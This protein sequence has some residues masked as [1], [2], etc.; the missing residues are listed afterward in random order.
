MEQNFKIG[1]IVKYTYIKYTYDYG[2]IISNDK[3]NK[4]LKNIFWFEHKD[5]MKQ[6]TE[7]LIK[8]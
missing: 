6:T 8:I 3:Y 1:D 7:Y 2:I 5:I 4:K